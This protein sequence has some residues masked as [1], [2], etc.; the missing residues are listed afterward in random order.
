MAMKYLL[1]LKHYKFTLDL[2]KAEINNKKEAGERFSTSFDES[3][4]VTNR[5]FMN[6]N[7]EHENGYY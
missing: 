5:R 2:V 7:L 1:A 6:L 4:S 3:T